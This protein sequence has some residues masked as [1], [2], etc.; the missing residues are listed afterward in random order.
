MSIYLFHGGE[1]Y[2]AEREFQATW[3]RLTEG[4]TSDL[5][6]EMLDPGAAPAEVVLAAGTIGFFS[7]VRVV[8]IRDWK[9]LLP[10]AGRR[11]TKAD[12][13][14]PAQAAATALADL[15]DSAHLLL[16]AG[17]T[18]SATHPVLKLAQQ[19][20]EVRSFARLRWRDLVDWATRRAR[21]VG[22]ALDN[23]G[24]RALVNATGDD[25]R[26]IDAELEKLAT[27]AAG[28][29]LGEAEV[30]LLVPDTAEHQVWDLTDSLLGDPGRAAMEL[31]RALG[32]GEPAG[33][34]SYMLV[35]HLR[36]VLAASDARAR[37]AGTRELTA[38]FS[39]DGRPLSDYAVEK[40]FTQ[41]AGVDRTRLEGLYRRAA[42][43]EASQR[44]GELGEE[45]AL[46]LLVLEA[47]LG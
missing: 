8:G 11:R 41:A 10:V 5:D 38:A 14:D 31:D 15:P 26:L 27:Y 40:A 43:V 45:E 32:S 47:A 33:R 28:E 23:A 20:G 4:L 30:R 37:S 9:P 29:R 3:H 36:L 34:L 39:G 21:E 35:R 42:G 1:S 13:D 25:L 16:L 22:L 7:P 46:R 6:A 19:H 17:V 44:R 18:V 2:L 12:A 24:A